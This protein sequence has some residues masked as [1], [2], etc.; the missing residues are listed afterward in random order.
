MFGFDWARGFVSPFRARDGSEFTT[1][2]DVIA[3]L[4]DQVCSSTTPP[5]IVDMGSGD[6]RIVHEAARRGLPARGIELDEEL[7]AAARKVAEDERLDCTFEHASLLEASVPTEADV[8]CY[9]LP[10]A[11]VKL[12][13]KLTQ[14]GHRGRLFA[15]RWQVVDSA[16][17]ELHHRVVLAPSW[18][19]S[20]YR[21]SSSGGGASRSAGLAATRRPIGETA[22][23]VAAA[24]KPAQGVGTPD[25]RSPAEFL[26]VDG[27]EEWQGLPCDIFDEPNI[28]EPRCEVFEIP[29][30]DGRDCVRVRPQRAAFERRAP[31][32]PTATGGRG[33]GADACRMTGALLWDSAVVLSSYLVR[34]QHEASRAMATGE[35]CIEL[36]AGLGLV[37]LTAAALGLHVTLTDREECLPLLHE[38]VRSNS[39]LLGERASVAALEWGDRSAA[40]E[41]GPF[42]LILLSDCIYETE[43][44]AP[45][46]TTLEELLVGGGVGG[47]EREGAQ[48]EILLAYDNAIGRAAAAAE[49]RA[50]AATK[51]MWEDIQ[52]TSSDPPSGGSGA[53]VVW[54]G[55]VQL[56]RL[57]LRGSPSCETPP[58]D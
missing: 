41:L 33:S 31:L 19:L 27:S 22:P 5:M 28:V 32:N 35:S 1:P 15:I 10:P 11:L 55:S 49:F 45:L 17:W 40:R 6:G 42:R 54:K 37:G 12:A 38:G 21:L 4:L 13:N 47:G 36:G 7:V 14:D 23:P 30:G 56:A 29:L 2:D 51:F 48:P 39:A 58:P 53:D 50:R 3:R 26:E 9:L 18:P 52:Q 57:T 34:R 46:L 44:A 20:E 8:V 16:G 25:G 24:N 43:A